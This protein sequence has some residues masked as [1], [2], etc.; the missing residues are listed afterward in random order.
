MLKTVK[1]SMKWGKIIGWRA[2]VRLGG[3]PSS[4]RVQP[5]AGVL[6]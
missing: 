6:F 4:R 1:S 5:T 3:D 2:P